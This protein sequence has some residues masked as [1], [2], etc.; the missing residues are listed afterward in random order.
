MRK[1]EHH[2]RTCS[3]ILIYLLFLEVLVSCCVNRDDESMPCLDYD[4]K[5][6]E[7]QKLG[8]CQFYFTY[9][10]DVDE[11]YTE[12]VSYVRKNCQFS[13]HVPTNT[14]EQRM[15]F[16]DSPL[17]H[18]F[19]WGITE[20]PEIIEGVKWLTV[21]IEQVIRSSERF[22]AD[23][24]E[25]Q[26]NRTFKVIAETCVDRHPFCGLWT[27][28]GYCERGPQLM[29]DL[30]PV[31]CQSCTFLQAPNV[32]HMLYPDFRPGK[33]GKQQHKINEKYQHRANPFSR[34]DLQGVLEAVSQ[35]RVYHYDISSIPNNGLTDYVVHH[36]ALQPDNVNPDPHYLRNDKL[37]L[38]WDDFVSTSECMA[39]LDIVRYGIGVTSSGTSSKTTSLFVDTEDGFAPSTRDQILYQVEGDE[40]AETS[41]IIRSSSRIH[42]EPTLPTNMF[43]PVLERVLTKLE[44]F[45][46]ISPSHLEL[47]IQFTKFSKNDFQLPMSH[48][49]QGHKALN[50]IL[51][52]DYPNEGD[53][54]D[55]DTTKKTS[56]VVRNEKNQI[57]ID[58]ETKNDEQNIKVFTLPNIQQHKE[59]RMKNGRVFGMILF[60]GNVKEGGNITFP[61][62]NNL[63]I[64]PQI[65]RAIIFPTSQDLIGATKTEL[66]DDEEE[67]NDP[68]DYS[69]ADDDRQKYLAEDFDTVLEHNVVTAG[70]KYII[71]IYF[72]RYP[73]PEDDSDYENNSINEEEN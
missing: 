8:Y 53:L 49:S 5:C 4:K 22:Y 45:M 23:W 24:I 59:Y 11:D 73:N 25:Q 41:K 35:N 18:P 58:D 55:D 39:I 44:T 14:V 47:P 65:G 46:G 37:L 36:K 28:Q 2:K 34:N 9:L 38:Q 10:I 62:F 7:Y 30:C 16:T 12:R 52:S 31:L 61:N 60:L 42:V 71:S 63:T 3:I 26:Q 27:V 6:R 70:D 29:K 69:F 68:L 32:T 20:T 33:K 48:Y 17:T 13:C 19:E 1:S 64:A 72:R 66:D 51:P 50:K 67:I 57:M 21:R 54:D 43:A 15:N 40:E 56:K